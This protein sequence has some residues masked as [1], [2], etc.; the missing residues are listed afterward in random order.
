MKRTVVLIIIIAVLLISN[1][2]SVSVLIHEGNKTNEV[3]NVWDLGTNNAIFLYQQYDEKNLEEGYD[4]AIGEMGTIFNTIG[5]ID[6][7]GKGKLT[8]AQKAELSGFYT[9]LV[10]EKEFMKEHISEVRDIINLIQAED[11]AAFIKMNELRE[12]IFK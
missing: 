11:K 2:A 6:Y 1:I 3:R 7:G 12:S 5:F 9:N 8:D 4:F 10:Y